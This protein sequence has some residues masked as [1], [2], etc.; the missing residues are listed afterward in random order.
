MI[1]GEV[2]AQLESVIPLTLLAANGKAFTMSAVVDTGFA[3]TLILPFSVCA[4]M[5]YEHLGMGYLTLADGSEVGSKLHAATVLWDDQPREIEAD[6]LDGETFV[7][8]LLMKGYRLCTALEVGG[9]VTLE[10]LPTKS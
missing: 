2:N 1:V 8:V 4:A 6:S 9:A 10:P 7:G 3:G 5:G